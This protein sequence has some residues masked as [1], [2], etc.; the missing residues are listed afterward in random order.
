MSVERSSIEPPVAVTRIPPS[1]GIALRVETARPAR[2]R[3]ER[4]RSWGTENFIGR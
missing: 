1:D 2:S 3:R 4:R